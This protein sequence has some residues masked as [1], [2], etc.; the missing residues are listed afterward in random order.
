M[1]FFN[2]SIREP[3]DCRAQHYKNHHCSRQGHGTGA[4]APG[5]LLLH[6]ARGSV[7]DA[8]GTMGHRAI[9]VGLVSGKR[10]EQIAVSDRAGAR[11][12]SRIAGRTRDALHPATCERIWA[13]S[14]LGLMAAMPLYSLDFTVESGARVTLEISPNDSSS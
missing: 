6:Y 5:F 13:R 1:L 14:N 2:Q 8:A 12:R 3:P 10:R 9:P 11:G 7:H 4:L